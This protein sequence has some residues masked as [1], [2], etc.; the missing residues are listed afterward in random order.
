MNRRDLIALFG[1]TA[2][3]WPVGVRAQQRERMRRVG[4]LMNF[5]PTDLEGQATLCRFFGG[6]TTTG[7]D[8][9]PQCA[10]RQ[11]LGWQRC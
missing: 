4:A 6:P 7:L 8:Q 5:A 3:T 2:A 9:R 10:D 1:S 11:P